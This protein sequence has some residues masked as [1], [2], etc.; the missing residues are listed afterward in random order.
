MIDT[1]DRDRLL[2]ELQLRHE[3]ID[4]GRAF[5]R[6]SISVPDGIRMNEI[7]TIV[8][9]IVQQPTA[10]CKPV[11][12]SAWMYQSE[13]KRSVPTSGKFICKYCTFTF[14]RLVGMKPFK[15]CPE[16]GAEMENGG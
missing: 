14:P 15:L 7:E 1:I 13:D 10:N 9:I 5:R 6:Q 11:V 3:R 8:H 4:G 16:C 2:N 12:R